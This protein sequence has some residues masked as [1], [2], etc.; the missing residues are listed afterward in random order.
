MGPWAVISNVCCSS[1]RGVG[2]DYLLSLE[3]A[4]CPLKTQ[5]G[6]QDV[7]LAWTILSAENGP[8]NNKGQRFFFRYWGFQG[9]LKSQVDFPFPTFSIPPPQREQGRKEMS[10]SA[11]LHM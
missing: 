8:Q 6:S 7:L 4:L 11:V 1:R 5:R 2:A 3:S 10:G 9:G